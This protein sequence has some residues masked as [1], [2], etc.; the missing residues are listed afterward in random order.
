MLFNFLFFLY[1]FLCVQNVK[2]QEDLIPGLV[3]TITDGTVTNISLLNYNVSANGKP[4]YEAM[5][6]INPNIVHE[7]KIDGVPADVHFVLLQVHSHLRNLTLSH[8][9]IVTPNSSI[10]GTNI[11]LV[12]I[13][14]STTMSFFLTTGNFSSDTTILI[15]LH[16]YG[17]DAPIPGGCNM[18]FPV[19]ISPFLTTTNDQAIT[20]V[21]FA[22]ASPPSNMVKK[23]WLNPTY[24]CDLK[25]SP[26][27]YDTY[28]M[29][30]LE[31]DFSEETY[32]KAILSMTTI[33]RIKENGVFIYDKLGA[34]PVRRLFAAYPGTGSAYVVVARTPISSS[35]YVPS[36]TYDCDASD[37]N[38]TCQVL[39]TVFSKVFCA[40]I[41]F[42]GFVICFAG[43][44]FFKL[45]L[46][47]LGFFPGALVS[48][49]ILNELGHTSTALGLSVFI[50]LITGAITLILWCCCCG[51]PVISIILATVAFGYIFASMLFYP[52]VDAVDA[53]VSDINY[54]SVFGGIIIFF[55]FSMMLL[56]EKANI[57]S[58]SVLGSYAAIVPIDHYIGAN[59]RYIIINTIRR[60]TVA[61][62][63]L[64][65]VHPPFQIMDMMLSGSWIILVLLGIWVQ[66]ILVKQ[67]P[68][69]P[70]PDNFFRKYTRMLT[71]R[72]S[73]PLIDER[74]P[75]FPEVD[76]IKA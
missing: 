47:L 30:V 10:N 27:E 67:K 5:F 66:L 43:H 52:L 34:S 14:Y 75:L 44:F 40:V 70:A 23:W 51:Y 21:S 63:K 59:L 1:V 74:T 25:P 36:F 58:C 28:R 38:N 31:R 3:P 69:F 33:D 12:K 56:S 6:K 68:P 55:L 54:W 37:E 4:P 15:I 50:G 18:E 13:V 57:I 61:R 26:V 20:D 11:G 65:V 45:E 35:V 62:F 42:L 7:I 76:E 16:A 24:S 53:F 19:E 49:V 46:F 32:F 29:Y 72:S 17:I 71:G 48:N 8:N 73:S 2:T 9:K 60:A 39:T 64:A 41:F 22:P